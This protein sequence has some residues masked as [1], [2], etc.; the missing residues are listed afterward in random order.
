M[1]EITIITAFFDIG[2][3]KYAVYSRSVDKYLDYFRFWAGIKNKLI[4]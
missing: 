4:V 1:R 3:D 2:R